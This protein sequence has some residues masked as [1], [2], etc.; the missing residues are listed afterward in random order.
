MEDLW[1]ALQGKRSAHMEVG[2]QGVDFTALGQQV[3]MVAVASGLC[4]EDEKAAYDKRIQTRLRGKLVHLYK[5]KD[6]KQRIC[7]TIQ[8][9]TLFYEIYV[10]N[11]TC[12]DVYLNYLV[13]L[14]MIM[15]S[16][17]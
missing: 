7:H 2:T 14:Y 3:T 11:K 17:R 16:I 9:V 12:N 13:Q 4:S 10:R 8:L 1:L 5:M 6:N 15:I